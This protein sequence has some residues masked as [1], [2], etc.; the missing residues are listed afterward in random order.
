MRAPQ[1]MASVAFLRFPMPPY[2]S[3]C[4]TQTLYR[5]GITQ[6]TISSQ[7]TCDRS[8]HSRADPPSRHIC[9]VQVE[10]GYLPLPAEA[11]SALF[12]VASQRY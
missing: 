9:R 4:P 6:E 5:A 1:S 12:Q 8:S 7:L 3:A 11:A 2:G 10:L